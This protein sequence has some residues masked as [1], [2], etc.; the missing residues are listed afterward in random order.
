MDF[1]WKVVVLDDEAPNPDCVRDLTDFGV[2]AI[3]LGNPIE[4]L[5][6]AA[7]LFVGVDFCFC[8]MNWKNEGEESQS[9]KALS[10]PIDL[11]E[12]RA[13]FVK[14][15]VAAIRHWAKA[16][17]TGL[18]NEWPREHVDDDD[19]GLWL[20]AM[21]KRLSPA[22]MIILFSAYDITRKGPLAAIGRFPDTPFTVFGKAGAN[23]VPVDFFRR[24]L[25]QA[26]AKWLRERLDIQRW[27]LSGVMIPSLAGLEP[28][29]ADILSLQD[30]KEKV[31]FRAESFFPNFV[32]NGKFNAQGTEIF[33]EFLGPDMPVWQEV[34]MHALQ[35]RLRRLQ[36]TSPTEIREEDLRELDSL[37]N[38]CGEAGESV[39]AVVQDRQDNRLA[40]DCNWLNEASKLCAVAL[41][42]R[43]EDLISLCK[44][45]RGAI[46]YGESAQT[47]KPSTEVIEK[48]NPRLPFQYH[49]L[50]RSVNALSD[51]AAGNRK[52][53][54]SGPSISCL[55]AH[56]DSGELTITWLDDSI[57][58]RDFELF[59]E[60][61]RE[62]VKGKGSYRGI[63]LAILFGLRFNALQ[64]EILINGL[65]WH[66]LWPCGGGVVQNSLNQN[67]GFGFRWT[68][69]YTLP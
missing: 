61:L 13:L 69:R 68:F 55:N 6:A 34:A 51:N 64:I 20:A 10:I 48:T 56:I 21:V 39:R 42:S 2:S 25:K 36:V 47:F 16:T 57:G 15:W 65:Q 62:S 27:F 44:E 26:Q 3:A 66:T 37:C 5:W 31:T 60:K 33:L 8:D 59:K 29:T 43:E 19:F 58:F 17:T 50:R 46:T 11:G 53:S 30:K 49:Y 1:R 24:P 52:N 41:A 9:G 22:A 4:G 38:E 7:D 45:N 63:P 12:D 18:P 40:D 14:E 28:E 23:P 67:M 32:Q 54:S 35:H